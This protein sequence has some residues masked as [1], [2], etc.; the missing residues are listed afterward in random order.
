MRLL[1]LF[2]QILMELRGYIVP[3]ANTQKGQLIAWRGYYWI[4]P[5]HY[6]IDNVSPDILLKIANTIG[7]DSFNEGDTGE[8]F[9]D[10][11]SDLIEVRPDVIWGELHNNEL[12]YHSQGSGAQSPIT[13]SMLKKLAQ[14]LNLDAIRAENIDWNGDEDTTSIGKYQMK[15]KIQEVLFHGTTSDYMT[16]IARTGIRPNARP[17]NW[18]SIGIEHQGIIFGA[19]TVEGATFHANKTSGMQYDPDDQYRDPD[20]AFPVVLEFKIPDPNRIVPDYDVAS[21]VLGHTDQTINLGYTD[22]ESYGLFARSAEVS[23]HNPEGRLWK[24]ASVFGYQGRVPANHIIRVYTNF[25]DDGP[26]TGNYSWS[27]SLKEFFIEWEERYKD[28]HGEEE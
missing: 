11:L 10:L 25:F 13:S 16:S 26:L 14:E 18:K 7:M 3:G 27:G 17:S 2:E 28:W 4:L 22:K 15:G 23:K 19:A 24:A 8:D 9:I 5:T 6:E 12:Y 21:G 1:D 20:D